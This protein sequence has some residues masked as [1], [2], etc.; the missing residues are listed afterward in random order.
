MTTMTMP[1][2]A[3]IQAP[4]SYRKSVEWLRGPQLAALRR[5]YAA[6][7]SISDERGF[8]YWAGLHGLPL[9]MY[10]EHHTDL[11]LPWHRAYLYFFELTLKDLEPTVSLPWWDWTSSA[12]HQWGMPE[13]YTKDSGDGRPNPLTGG[14]ISELARRQGDARHPAPERTFRLPDEPLRLPRRGLVEDILDLGDFL[15]FSQQLE[16]IHDDVHVWIGGTVAEIPYA[17]Y[18]PIFWVHH[19]MIDRLWRLWQLRHP[20]AGV[21]HSLLR[22][23]LPPF[24][25]TVADTVSTTALGYDYAVFS[26]R[27]IIGGEP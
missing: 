23:A 3:V 1:A 14:E 25:I 12:A 8:G 9:P 18:D 7:M 24:P 2:S 11:F 16:Q 19:S 17:A 10:C 21:P 20:T 6:S 13:A 26:S 5:A 4:L 15:D 22:T 27:T